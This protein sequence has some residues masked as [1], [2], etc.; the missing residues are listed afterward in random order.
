[1]ITGAPIKGVTALMGMMP[2][3]PGRTLSMLHN[4]ST[5]APQSMV[6]GSSVLWLLLRNSKRAMCGTDKPINVI[7]PQKAVVEAVSKPVAK[8]N[9]FLV[10]DIFTPKFS[11]YLVPNSMALRGLDSRKAIESP[12]KDAMV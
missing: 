3:L 12:H 11:A 7:G 9:R 4:N 6:T 1:M 5:I 2:L 8:S 10:K